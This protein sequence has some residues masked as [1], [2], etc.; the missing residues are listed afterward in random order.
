M[1]KTSPTAEILS[2][3]DEV[4]TGQTVDTNANWIAERL[5][6]LGFTILRHTA[7]GDRLA[8]IRSLIRDAAAR[9]SVCICTGGLGP[10]EDDL[11]A[12]A[13]S[14]AFDRP[15]ELDT[16]SLD[17]IEGFYKRMNR[18]MP[19]V[20]R[21]Q[22]YLPQGSIRLDND[23]GTA[24]GFVIE[25][26][27]SFLAFLPGVP[28]EMKQMIP[29][30]VEPLLFDRFSLEPGRLVTLRTVGIGESALQEK[31]GSFKHPSV[32]LSYRTMHPENQVKLR[33]PGNFPEEE[34]EK[35]VQEVVEKIGS[36]I[37]SIEGLEAPGGS[38]VEVLAR[39]L[40][41]RNERIS[42]AEISTGGHLTATCSAIDS[43]SNWL[44]EAVLLNA[45]ASLSSIGIEE[46]SVA[47]HGPI[48]APVAAAMAE[49]IR[50]KS[51]ATY[52]LATTAMESLENTEGERAV[53]VVY[54][55]LACEKRTY[56]RKLRVFGDQGRI[57][58]MGA[59]ETLDLLRRLFDGSIEDVL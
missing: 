11:T 43:W 30:R 44:N 13:V 23:W 26:G 45:D 56:T 6:G 19:D 37:F 14:E 39:E 8:D 9:A 5:T 59:A 46:R 38:L 47:G 35:M 28:R 48:S 40:Q 54:V 1:K 33:F 3:G 18:P 32:V 41:A 58:R 31:I 52:G 49:T 10:T 42:I 4:V 20:N 16:K 12:Q 27:E 22:A 15:L 55:A 50:T 36:S 25:Q 17:R 21:K 51:N 29:H 24:P 34:I 53:G 2:Q 57:R 7:V